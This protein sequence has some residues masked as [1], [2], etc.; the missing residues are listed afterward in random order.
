M[1]NQEIHEEGYEKTRNPDGNWFL[2]NRSNESLRLAY[3]FLWNYSQRLY[4]GNPE[5]LDKTFFEDLLVFKV[6]LSDSGRDG[7]QNYEQ[8]MISVQ[9]EL[10][11][12]VNGASYPGNNHS[13]ALS[14]GIKDSEYLDQFFVLMELF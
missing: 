5:V 8:L 12:F 9:Q 1:T 4:I 13:G 3:L 14:L 10:N 6:D 11:Y 7:S 2:N